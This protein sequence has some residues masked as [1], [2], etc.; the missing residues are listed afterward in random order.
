[1]LWV[2]AFDTAGNKTILSRALR[3][4]SNPPVVGWNIGNGAAISN[5]NVFGG[6][7][8][9]SNRVSFQIVETNA[10]ATNRF[11]NGNAWQSAAPNGSG[12]ELN[13]G[14]AGASWN[15]GATAL[16][17]AAQLRN[18]TFT[19][20]VRAFNASGTVVLN[21]IHVV[22]RSETRAP[23]ISIS[24]PLSGATFVSFPPISGTAF[25]G[26]SAPGVAGSG[27]LRADFALQRLADGKYW[28]GNAWTGPTGLQAPA[29]RMANGNASWMY[30]GALPSG[31]AL[32]NGNY[33]LQAFALDIAGNRSAAATSNFSI[34]KAAARVASPSSVA[35]STITAKPDG[36]IRLTFT[37]ALGASAGD[38]SNYIVSDG[39]ISIQ[40][41]AQPNAST[42]EFGI[43]ALQSGTRI[44]VA[45]DIEDSQ[46]RAV[47]GTAN[48]AV[49]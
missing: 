10:P 31:A 47:Q 18:G 40:T 14:I 20:V 24:S 17:S 2:I 45:Y 34:L 25:D 19:L 12:P 21:V 29:T 38:A 48:V 22:K 32:Q 44:S 41:I 37:G 13:G 27:V 7:L 8:S 46:G 3:I 39:A 23:T 42:V 6:P 33:R 35:L 30:G 36:T 16:P 49:R 11:W 5:L 28:N 15:R 43:G 4:D 9:Q 1:M 26:E